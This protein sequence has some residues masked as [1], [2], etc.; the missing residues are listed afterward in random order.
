MNQVD[1]GI[2]FGITNS[3]IVIKSNND[4]S[5]KSLRSE[6]NIHLSLNNILKNFQ[7][8]S[9]IKSI[10]VTGGKHLDLPDSFDG[11]KIVKKNEIDCIGVGA[12]K[13]SQLDSNF[14]VLSCG[15]GTACVAYEN[16]TTTH[17]GGTGLGGGTIRGLCKLAVQIDDPDEIDTLSRKGSQI[18]DYTLKDVI[19]GPIGNLPED[20]IAVHLGNL[21][22]MNKLEK[23]DICKSIIYLVATNVARL[24]ATTALAAKL[25]KIVVVG[26]S[27]NY[28]L[29]KEVLTRWVE[30]SGLKVIFPENREFATALGTLEV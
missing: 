22:M 9:K 13:L 17:L 20:S 27:P 6:K 25:N 3:D 8:D 14:L 28:S 29:Y 12:K 4:F 7:K 16:E 21:D 15:S 19:S 2:D 23:E 18:G 24:A 5:Y 11:K 1:I 10:S 30:F 26:R